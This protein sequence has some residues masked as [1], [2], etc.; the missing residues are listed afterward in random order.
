MGFKEAIR[1]KFLEAAAEAV[2][3]KVNGREITMK[4]DAQL[5][6]QI[7]E[8]TSEKIQRGPMTNLLLEMTEGLWAE[9]LSDLIPAAEEWLESLKKSAAAK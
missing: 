3:N 6:T 2:D 1:N 5:D 7:G 8:K 9:N 4:L